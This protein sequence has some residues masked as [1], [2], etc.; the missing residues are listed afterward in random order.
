M[1]ISTSRRSIGVPVAA[2]VNLA[3][4]SDYI[5]FERFQGVHT[6]QEHTATRRLSSLSQPR[7]RIG[8]GTSDLGGDP[9]RG[10]W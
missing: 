2:E 5:T 6:C 9:T 10:T 3:W 4:I 7:A 8:C 1:V